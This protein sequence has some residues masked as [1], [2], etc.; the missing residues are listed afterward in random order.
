MR[1]INTLSIK[2]QKNPRRG[3]A[4]V[5]ALCQDCVYLVLYTTLSGL[6]DSE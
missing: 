4:D 1:S 3:G 5:V 6:A 2:K